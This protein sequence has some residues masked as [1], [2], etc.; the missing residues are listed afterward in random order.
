MFFLKIIQPVKMISKNPGI[1]QPNVKK[2]VLIGLLLCLP[3]FCCKAQKT[4]QARVLFGI[5]TD[6]HK[7]IMVDADARLSAFIQEAAEK[8]PDFIIQLGDFCRPYDYNQNFLSI[9][10]SYPGDKYHVI[11]NHEMDGGFTREQVVN[12]M[13][14]PAKYYSFDKHNFHFI[15]LDGNDRN[16]AP[17]RASGYARYI[18]EEQ[19]SW[20]IS[21]LKSTKYPVILFSHQTLEG[22]GIE[23]RNDIRGIL[24]SEN[25]SA[26][27]NKVIAC[28]SGH[29]HTDYSTRING[30]Y[31]I[32]INSMS[33]RWVGEKYQVI[34]YS[35]EIDNKFPWIKS[36]IPYK[37]PL[38]AF[39]EIN[40]RHII[41]KGK[42]SSYIGPGPV[43]MGMPKQPENDQIT[44]LI[45]NRK[46]KR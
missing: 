31:Y 15:V 45:R 17:D 37:D 28:F 6:V 41:I 40:N 32:Q 10:N 43:E 2:I 29:H 9:W 11:G 27:C 23:N 8:K 25:R 3:F 33:Y 46:L 44:P 5:C 35:Q 34:R 4:G 18:G 14:S 26:G 13:K 36:T 7:D 39:V 21:D 12:Y 22:D 42:K 16:P 19:K 24:E 38:F 1:M 20:L 30:I